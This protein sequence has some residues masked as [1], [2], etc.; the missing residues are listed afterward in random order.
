MFHR[1]NAKLEGEGETGAR[2]FPCLTCNVAFRFQGH[3]DRHYRHGL[4]S[5]HQK[6]L[7]RQ[8]SFFKASQIAI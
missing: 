2:K 7:H 3:L 5:A 1:L 8:K 6:L 4:C